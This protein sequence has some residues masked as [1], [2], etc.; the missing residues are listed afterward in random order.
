M[1]VKKQNSTPSIVG[2]PLKAISN[3]KTYTASPQYLTCYLIPFIEI[4]LLGF[5]TVTR[6]Y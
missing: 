1:T 4:I 5:C 3:V 2:H 6:D